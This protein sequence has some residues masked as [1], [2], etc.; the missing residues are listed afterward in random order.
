MAA[1]ARTGSQK[2]TAKEVRP[3]F[4][5]AAANSRARRP[6]RKTYAPSF[7]NCFA[8]PRPMPG[9]ID[10]PGLSD[11]LASSGGGPATLADAS[12]H[13]GRQQLIES[14][15]NIYDYSV[16]GVEVNLGNKFPDL[17]KI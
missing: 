10:T 15:Q 1:A 16:G 3:I 7:T 12:H 5:A 14:G 13:S 4:L 8:V 17:I 9:S 11:L 6:H 2:M